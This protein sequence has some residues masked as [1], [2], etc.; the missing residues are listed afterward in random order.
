[1]FIEPKNP[2]LMDPETKVPDKYF[3]IAGSFKSE[4]T[5]CCLRP[6]YQ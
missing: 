6:F 3:Q 1:M 2:E 4:I 5:L